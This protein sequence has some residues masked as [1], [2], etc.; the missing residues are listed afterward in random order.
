MDDIKLK[1]SRELINQNKAKLRLRHELIVRLDN[2]LRLYNSLLKN[3]WFD[4]LDRVLTEE[5]GIP[6]E[7]IKYGR[8]L[9]KLVKKEEN[10]IKKYDYFRA[11]TT[12]V[13][14]LGGELGNGRQE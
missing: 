2:F 6:T 3:N 11:L 12:L 8:T 4:D 7:L 10:L 1:L 13:E 9:I 5:K 14:Y